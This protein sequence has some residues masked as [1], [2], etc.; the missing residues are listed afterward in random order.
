MKKSVIIVL[1]TVQLITALSFGEVFT[2]FAEVNKDYEDRIIGK[3][4]FSNRS[5]VYEFTNIFVRKIDG[6]HYFKY[7][8]SKYP[9]YEGFLY[10]I[11]KSKK[12]SISFFC[13]GN[14]DKKRGLV[15]VSSRIRFIGKDKFVV[16]SK[17]NI[18]EIYFTAKRID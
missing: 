8:S 5:Y 16:F 1:F 9:G 12:T 2:K 6:F 11:F 17:N 13:R 4:I 7:K 14:W 3:W 18:N 15:H 10:A